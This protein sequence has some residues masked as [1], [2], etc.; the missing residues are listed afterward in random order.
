MI[1]LRRKACTSEKYT[2]ETVGEMEGRKKEIGQGWVVKDSG[3]NVITIDVVRRGIE[4]ETER[5]REMCLLSQSRCAVL[6]HLS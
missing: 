6:L 2:Q 5:A 3:L 1:Y 4:R